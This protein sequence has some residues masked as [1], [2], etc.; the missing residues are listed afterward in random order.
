STNLLDGY[1]YAAAHDITPLKEAEL[2]LQTSERKFRSFV[3][4][5]YEIISIIGL[6][7]KYTYHSDSLFRVLGYKPEELIGLSA[8]ELV[9]PEDQEKVVKSTALLHQTNF[10]NN[11]IPYRIKASDGTY[12][13]LE[14]SG[15][16]MIKDPSI[17]GIVVNSR[18][19][20]DKI[21]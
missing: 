6:E 5:G 13:W 4:N 15:T 8:L 18:D 16:N 1:L 10:V 12:K 7:G 2:S 20:T 17:Q 19:V 21:I 9:H 3:Q 14:S 11:G